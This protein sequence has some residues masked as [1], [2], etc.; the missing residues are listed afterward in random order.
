[1]A[2]GEFNVYKESL[3]Y[4]VVRAH[5]NLVHQ[6]ILEI[7]FAFGSK[8]PTDISQLVVLVVGVLNVSGE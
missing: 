3:G 8:N 1:M 6:A 2:M 4:G 5:G 7:D